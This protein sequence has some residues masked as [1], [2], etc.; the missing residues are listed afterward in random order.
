[1]E[2]KEKIQSCY[3]YVEGDTEDNKKICAMCIECRKTKYKDWGW[4]YDGEGKG[5]GP[6]EYRC[7]KCDKVIYRHPECEE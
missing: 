3:F 4:F 6:F 1:M 2:T 7:A 5:Y